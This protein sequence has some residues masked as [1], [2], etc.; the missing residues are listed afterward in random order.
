MKTNTQPLIFRTDIGPLCANCAVHKALDNHNDI[1]SWSID[2]EDKD[3]VLRIVSDTLTPTMIIE[4]I[5]QL[6]HQC[7][8]LS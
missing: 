2:A 5:N 6:G 7:H 3:C 1:Q 8:E 4:I